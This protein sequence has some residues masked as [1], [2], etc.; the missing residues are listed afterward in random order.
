MGSAL[1]KNYDIE[2]EPY[3]HGGFHNFWKVYRG[4]KK[5]APHNEV[6]IF[7]FDK[8]QGKTKKN[9]LSA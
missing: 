5:T 3:M 9:K 2:K 8:K 7:M 1:T 6:S 4:K